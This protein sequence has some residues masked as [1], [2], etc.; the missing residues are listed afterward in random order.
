M[1]KEKFLKVASFV[2]AI[3]L[4]IVIFYFSAQHSDESAKT[5]LL[6]L[7]W[8]N[9][10]LNISLS[11]DFVRT[12]AHWF[13]YF[14]LSSCLSFALFYNLKRISPVAPVIICFLY[15]VSD[16]VHQIFVP[17]RAF[18]LKDIMVDVCGAAAGILIFLVIVFF[19]GKLKKPET[20]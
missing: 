11:H 15:S 4:M 18:Q 9:D 19:I 13:E 5:S 7:N 10:V 14:L 16:E 12:A 8:L 3:V 20:V 1:K 6:F 2:P 17:G